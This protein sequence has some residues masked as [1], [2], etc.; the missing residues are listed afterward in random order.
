MPL[1]LPLTEAG[2]VQGALLRLGSQNRYGDM[3]R[4]E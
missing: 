4:T 1:T 3:H 2:H